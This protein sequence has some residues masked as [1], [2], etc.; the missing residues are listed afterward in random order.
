[1]STPR[2]IVL[3]A[4]Y[5]PPLGGIGSHRALSFAR[6]LPEFG[7]RAVVVTPERGAYGLDPSLDPAAGA[8][9]EVVRTGSFEPAVLLRKL[10]GGKGT[11][12]PGGD[13]VEGIGTG[14]AARLARRLLH[15]SVYFP[16][17]ARG[18]IGPA[19]RAAVRAGREHDAVAVVSTSPPVS[20]HVAA[21]GAARKLGVP[22][23]L[24]FRD[25]WTAHRPAGARGPRV[26]VERRLEQS[27]LGRAA[28]VST[29]SE[30]WRD[31]LEERLGHA[32]DKPF[33][34]LRNGFEPTAFEGPAPAREPGVF[35]IVH[36]GTVYGAFQD[37]SGF[38]RALARVRDTGGFGALRPEVLLA[39]KVWPQALDAARSA[40]VLDLLRLPGFVTHA[41]A[42]AHQRSASVNLLLTW[43]VPGVVA[44]GVCPGKMYEQIAA[45]RPI[46]ALALPDCEAAGLLAETGGA[47]ILRPAD[48]DS[49]AAALERLARA[50]AQ[51]DAGSVV[52]PRVG[53]PQRFS[54]RSVAAG[55]ARLVASVVD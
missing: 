38:F 7:F 4:Y 43:T 18:W 12:G 11:G 45:G 40:G 47:L 51:G 34:V 32:S 25:L 24:D 30:A 53:D 28:A 14:G 26:G 22:A 33:E 35:R 16:D 3:I 9:V 8:G 2:T 41:E 55:L 42:V 50:E 27:L 29:V 23:V 49:I 6:H 46:L 31:W 21:V 48:E 13:F 54:R 37:L 39:G 19:R 17:H 1:V 15:W 44:R 36:T 20:G 5:Y 52:P 10:R